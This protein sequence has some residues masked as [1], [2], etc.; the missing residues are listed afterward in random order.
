MDRRLLAQLYQE[1][2]REL[3]LY[4]YSICRS[5]QMAEDLLQETFLKA[6]LSLPDAHTNMRAW[7]YKVARNLTCNAVKKA[8]RETANPNAGEKTDDTSAGGNASENTD[9]LAKVLQK[10][11]YKI[12]YD[13]LQR[14]AKP[15]REIL[16]MQYFGRLS[17]KEI[18]A[19]LGLSPDNVRVMASRGRK[20]LKRYMEEENYDL[21]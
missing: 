1:Y 11:Q 12:L 2:Y 15:Y 21:S 3:Y 4:V 5:R 7:L 18:A 8:G 16:I 6:I 10:E 20:A 9:P 14:L 17:H 13:G 19:V